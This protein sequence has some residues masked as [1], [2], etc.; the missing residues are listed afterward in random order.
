MLLNPTPKTVIYFY[1]VW[2]D[3]YDRMKDDNPD[4]FFMD[5]LPQSTSSLRAILEPHQS[6]GS[7]VVFDDFSDEIGQ[8]PEMFTQL[9][10][11]LSH[12]LNCTPVIIIH[13]LYAKNLRTI[14]LNTH[15]V[16]LTNNVRDLSQITTLSRQSFPHTGG[17][18]EKSYR[19]A[20]NTSKGYPHL[21]INFSPGDPCIRVMSNLFRENG[22]HYIRVYK[23]RECTI[24]K[25]MSGNPYERL[26]LISQ[27]LYDYL[28]NSS[29]SIHPSISSNDTTST[30]SLSGNNLSNSSGSTVSGVGNNDLHISNYVGGEGSNPRDSSSNKND[31]TSMDIYNSSANADSRSGVRATSEH[32]KASNTGVIEKTPTAS[33]REVTRVSKSNFPPIGEIFKKPGKRKLALGGVTDRAGKLEDS[34]T[35]GANVKKSPTLHNVSTPSLHPSTNGVQTPAVNHSA[36]RGGKS[37]SKPRRKGVKS[38][39]NSVQKSGVTHSGIASSIKPLQKNMESMDYMSDN[40]KPRDQSILGKRKNQINQGKKFVPTKITKLNRG[41]KRKNTQ[42]S[43]GRRRKQ[44][45]VTKYD[46]NNLANVAYD[47]WKL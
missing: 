18:L 37:Q 35:G 27:T 32:E 16:V 25:G 3:S 6:D 8:N 7:F 47:R 45:V 43:G 10:T 9:Y 29:K 38:P 39:L 13:N 5:T 41:E 46:T 1:K 12:H 34:T 31:R 2:Q 15:R 30:Q 36:S 44:Q 40:V 28:K 14:S 23:P 4:I 24:S 19:D 26:L 22:E 21:V 11:V 20:M 33:A 42:D 17:F